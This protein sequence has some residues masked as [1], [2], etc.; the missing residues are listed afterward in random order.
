[1]KITG[2]SI[3]PEWADPAD[4]D[5]WQD[6]GH[7]IAGELGV[8]DAHAT[9]QPTLDAE[10]MLGTMHRL[11]SRLGPIK[12][13]ELHMERVNPDALSHAFGGIPIHVVP[14]LPVN[15]MLLSTVGHWELYMPRTR[16]RPFTDLEREG[17]CGRRIVRHGLAD[18]LEW[19][20]EDVGG[21][22]EQAYTDHLFKVEVY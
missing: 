2:L 14:G 22:P 15:A 5:S 12:P 17:E 3:A 16:P 21:T 8:D 19:L 13:L 7:V 11:K 6:L 9:V 1:M 10:Q 4:P 18:V 20:G